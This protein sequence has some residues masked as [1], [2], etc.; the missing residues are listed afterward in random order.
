MKTI[1]PFALLSLAAYAS[2]EFYDSLDGCGR[3]CV[4]NAL[5]NAGTYGCAADVW[6][7]IC[8]AEAFRNAV[9]DCAA[10]SCPPGYVDTVTKAVAAHCDAVAPGA[11]APTST[12]TSAPAP[13]PTTAEAPTSA[14]SSSSEVSSTTSSSS[15][16]STTLQTSTT[17]HA[18]SASA[19]SAVSTKAATSATSTSSSAGAAATSEAPAATGS[20]GLNEAAKIGIGVGCG[21]AVIAI[22][23]LVACI[24]LRKRRAR[25]LPPAGI[26]RYKI[27]QPM[28]SDEHAYTHNNNSEYDIGGLSELEMKSRRYEDMLPRQQPQQPRQMV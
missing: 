2:A 26:D 9:R 11:A 1:R 14:S 28:P 18:T 21:A 10:K 17:S 5:N 22:L 24:F 25:E 19:S 12:S 27:S 13:T 23:A 3:D 15:L 6:N 4:K 16:T 20:S 8:P 7:C